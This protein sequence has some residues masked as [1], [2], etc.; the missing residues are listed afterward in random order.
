MQGVY[1]R[2]HGACKRCPLVAMPRHTP[3]A[4]RA[5]LHVPEALRAAEDRSAG[6][7]ALQTRAAWCVAPD[8]ADGGFPP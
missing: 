2:R 8:G 7:P 4:F 3:L 6:Y 1:Q 5:S